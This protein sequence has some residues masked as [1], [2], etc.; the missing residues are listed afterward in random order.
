MFIQEK[1]MPPQLKLKYGTCLSN[2][3]IKQTNCEG[4]CYVP[5]I[6][7]GEKVWQE[8]SSWERLWRRMAGIFHACS[9]QGVLVHNYLPWKYQLAC[10]RKAPLCLSPFLTTIPQWFF[11]SLKGLS[12]KIQRQISAKQPL[13]NKQ[14]NKQTNKSWSSTENRPP[15]V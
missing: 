14:T 13:Q 12:A 3:K 5:R 10:L 9:S 7:Q 2:N 8:M 11:L 1:W 4:L 6:R 15:K